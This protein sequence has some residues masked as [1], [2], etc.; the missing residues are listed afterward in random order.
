MNKNKILVTCPPMISSI[1]YFSEMFEKFNME[2]VTPK[3][4]QALSVK[5]LINIV[6]NFDGWIIGD[7]PATKEV[8]EAGKSGKLKAAIKWGIG[9]DN[10]DIEACKNLEIYFDNTPNQFGEEV[11]DIAMGYVIAL[12]R[13]TFEVDRKIRNFEW[14]K[15]VG[16]SLAGK[17]VALIGFGDIGKQTAKRLLAANMKVYIYDP[18]NFE[19][20][21]NDYEYKKWPDLLNYADFIVITCALTSS[22]YHMFNNQIFESKVKKGV[23]IVNVSRGAVIDQNSLESALKNGIVHSVALDVFE[24]EP[25]NKNSYLRYTPNSIFGSHNASNTIDAVLRASEQ[26]IIKLGNFLD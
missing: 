15:P 11:A 16:I 19:K 5:E 24:E 9:V 26:A 25:L 23:R 20:K 21:N 18:Q 6:P 12:A 13:H 10:V 8:F 1:N 2:I 3:I 14:P 22:S 7:D 17:T 4:I